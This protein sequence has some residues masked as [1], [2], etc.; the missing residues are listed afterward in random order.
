M[1]RDNGIAVPIADYTSPFS[2][3]TMDVEVAQP[4]TQNYYQRF[5]Q[6]FE[7]PFSMT[8]ETDSNGNTQNNPRAESFVEMLAELH[9]EEFSDS[10]HAVA[11]E[12]E[13]TILSKFNNETASNDQ[14]A[15]YVRER[16]QSYFT[17]LYQEVDSMID[18]VNSFLMEYETASSG[19]IDQ[20]LNE[21]QYEH[22][23]QLTPAQ[24]QFFGSVL[25]KV[26]G[27]V[28]KVKNIAEKFS[29]IHIALN[30][31]KGLIRPLLNKVLGSLIGKLPK[32]LQPIAQTLAKKFLNHEAAIED[33]GVAQ[34][35]ESLA[36]VDFD[37]MQ[38]EFDVHIANLVFE[39]ND[40]ESEELISN[41]AYASDPT[42][43]ESSQ[44]SLTDARQQFIQR[45]KD[46]EDVQVAMEQ[47]IPAIMG[48]L[49]IAIKLIGRP[50]VVN[51]LAGLVAKLVQKWVPAQTAKP[52]AASIVDLGLKAIN[53][54]ATDRDQED[55][56]YEAI[57]NTVE[58]AVR[59]IST[60]PEMDKL[61]G[62]SDSEAMGQLAEHALPAFNKAAANNFP[63]HF[64]KRNLHTS[65]DPDVWIL[66]PR[67]RKDKSY[68]KYTKVFSVSI[69]PQ[70]ASSIKTFGDG[71][72]AQFLKDTLS[73][74]PN[75]TF[76]ASVH[77]YES[78]PGTWLSKISMYERVRGL[79]SAD[80]SAWVQIH[81]LTVQA[82]TA[83]L[84]EPGLGKDLE[85]PLK[86]SHAKV[87]VG[88][89]FYY[90]EIGGAP[91]R[92]P[93][94]VQRTH[95]H[96]NGQNGTQITARTSDIQAVINFVR[97]VIALNYFFSEADA[98]QVVEKLNKN[99]LIGVAEGIRTSLRDTLNKI[100]VK[101]ASSKVKIVHESLPE[102]YL[103]HVPETEQFMGA[104]GKVAVEKVVEKMTEKLVDA[105]FQAVKDFLKARST[106]FKDALA[107]P[108][109][110]VTIQISWKNVPGMAQIRSVIKL[111]RGEGSL[112]DLKNI[113]FPSLNAPTLTVIEGKNF[114]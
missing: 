105:G 32:P 28:N 81:P 42:S 107:K 84:N 92:R 20:F 99:D 12:I 53:L 30:K 65:R 33:P 106:E 40:L 9:D 37:G 62:L 27:A 39:T 98:N 110:G 21:L 91:V 43:Y 89:R 57:A 5:S 67:R 6:D 108:E 83:L 36:G 75:D 1:A 63:G 59:T 96:K 79:G 68:K 22:D 29:P 25:K 111:I 2:D 114:K 54:E 48:A 11:N 69:T 87:A 46:G 10:L 97:S 17:P 64:I 14:Y 18:K 74:N 100:L 86:T 61:D 26:K 41:Y 31:I 23:G 82:A 88:Q 16:A 4:A 38:R 102:L 85:G 13:E 51:F 90:L 112:G 93:R 71:T 95:R 15:R 3:E 56:A 52:L 34:S 73:L 66:M 19:T 50:K 103:S 49:S 80:K 55:F 8:Y 45:L 77:I 109:D 44:P 60:E 70:L 58:E 76:Q 7:S 113:S 104:I 72:L 24:E 47:F 35:R 101:N 78:I 94:I